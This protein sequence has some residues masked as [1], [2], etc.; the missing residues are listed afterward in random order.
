MKKFRCI[1]IVEAFTDDGEMTMRRFAR[2]MRTA[3]RLAKKCKKGTPVMRK[4]LKEEHHWI[5]PA[6]V[7]G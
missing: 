3:E 1:Y 7:E 5:N 2:N 4:A 6:D